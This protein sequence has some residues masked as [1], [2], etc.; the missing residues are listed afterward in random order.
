MILYIL[1]CLISY[2][3]LI[4]LFLWL[5]SY[6]KKEEE[7]SDAITVARNRRV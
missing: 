4:A 5:R 2:I 7:I 1:A 6:V 3:P